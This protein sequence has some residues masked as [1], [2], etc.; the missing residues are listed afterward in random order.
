MTVT[1]TIA[2]EKADNIVFAVEAGMERLRKKFSPERP[3]EACCHTCGGLLYRDYVRL[4]QIDAEGQP[5][6]LHIGSCLTQFASSR[7]RA[8]EARIG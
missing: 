5:I 7:R 6:W 8:A 2:A 4:R 1:L 3:P